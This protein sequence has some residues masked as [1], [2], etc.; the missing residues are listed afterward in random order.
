MIE[1]LF[2]LFCTM[3]VVRAPVFAVLGLRK[4]NAR[5]TDIEHNHENPVRTQVR[6]ISVVTGNFNKHRWAGPALSCLIVL[7][8]AGPVFRAR[9]STAV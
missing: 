3:S 5:T 8:V 7:L 4:T 9:F 1:L 2:S 6:A